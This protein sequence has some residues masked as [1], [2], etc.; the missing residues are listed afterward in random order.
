MEITGFLLRKTYISLDYLANPG[1]LEQSSNACEKFD[2]S[3]TFARVWGMGPEA[4]YLAVIQQP[5]NLLVA[6]TRATSSRF[7]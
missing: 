5:F 2:I 1:N 3:T 6:L 4:P 7:R